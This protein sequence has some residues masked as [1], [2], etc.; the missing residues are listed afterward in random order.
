MWNH[1][2]I[3]NLRTDKNTNWGVALDSSATAEF[4]DHFPTSSSSS[5]CAKQHK[6]RQYAAIRVDDWNS[7]WIRCG[8][9]QVIIAGSLEEKIKIDIWYVHTCFVII[10]V[11]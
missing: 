11:G 8:V 2:S 9:V 1:L 7:S 10:H 4:A 3:Y 5:R 6:R